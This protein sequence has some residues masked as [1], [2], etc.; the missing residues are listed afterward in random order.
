MLEW[1]DERKSFPSLTSIGNDQLRSYL[2]GNLRIINTDHRKSPNP[3]LA[4]HSGH[5]LV[6]SG[7]SWLKVRNLVTVSID[8]SYLWLLD[9]RPDPAHACKAMRDMRAD[10][11]R[12]PRAEGVAK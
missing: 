9:G 3:L 5:V 4:T 6:E 7:H 12:C 1:G 8:W 2:A 11:G 10:M